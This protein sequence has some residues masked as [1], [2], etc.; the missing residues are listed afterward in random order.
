MSVSDILS[1]NILRFWLIRNDKIFRQAPAYIGGWKF[2]LQEGLQA[3]E[4]RA[5]AERAQQIKEYGLS[6]ICYNLIMIPKQGIG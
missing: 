1:S 6:S 4:I 2:Y 3:T 5:R